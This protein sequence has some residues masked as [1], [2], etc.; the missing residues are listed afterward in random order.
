MMRSHKTPDESEENQGQNNVAKTT[1]PNHGI[2]AQFDRHKT[3]YHGHDQ[4][5]VK[6]S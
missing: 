4:K 6:Q 5:P 2:A 1:V 3:T